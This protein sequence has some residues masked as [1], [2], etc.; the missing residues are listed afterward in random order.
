MVGIWIQVLQERFQNPVPG[1]WNLESGIWDVE[2]RI[3]DCLGF[4][5][6]GQLNT[7]FS[8]FL[9]QNNGFVKTV[10]ADN[11]WNLRVIKNRQASPL[12]NKS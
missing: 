12:E 4:P 3:Q 8:N 6:M 9:F 5:C 2:T 7:V 10:P 11:A 1:I